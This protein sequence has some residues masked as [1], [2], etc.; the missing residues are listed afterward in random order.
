LFHLFVIPI[1]LVAP[2]ANME[3]WWF[4]NFVAAIVFAILLAAGIYYV[5]EVPCRRILRGAAD[6][7]LPVVWRDTP[8]IAGGSTSSSVLP[9]GAPASRLLDTTPR[10]QVPDIW[11]IV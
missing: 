10:E 3:P 9:H 7:L 1:F 8:A 2:F 11:N 4:A 6:R 5:V